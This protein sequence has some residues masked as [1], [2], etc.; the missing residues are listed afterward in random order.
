M[1]FFRRLRRYGFAVRK[2]RRSFN[3]P[4]HQISRFQQNI[5]RRS[6]TPFRMTCGQ[7]HD[8]II[9]RLLIFVV[10][11]SN[12][13]C[14]GCLLTKLSLHRDQLMEE[15]FLVHKFLMSTDF[16]DLAFFYHYYPVAVAKSG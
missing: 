9:S 4:R 16:H 15:T 8:F 2:C 10:R 13:F 6:F 7:F 11:S 3:Y 1:S 12:C 14:F 5:P